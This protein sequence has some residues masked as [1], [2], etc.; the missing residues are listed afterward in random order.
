MQTLRRIIA[1]EIRFI[2]TEE[3]AVPLLAFGVP[4]A[5]AFALTV[6]FPK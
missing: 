2:T 3:I 1:R 6:I 5:F 4:L